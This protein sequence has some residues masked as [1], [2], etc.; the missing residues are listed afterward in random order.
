MVL[1]D[2]EKL[3]IVDDVD[4]LR[5]RIGDSMKYLRKISMI[6]N[7]G[8]Y[9]NKD[10]MSKLIQANK[11]EK[12]GLRIENNKIVITEDNFEDVLTLLNNDRLKSPI[13]EETF[14]VHVK[15]PLDKN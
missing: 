4:K 6:K 7:N 5:E 3:E 12:W 13:T 15:V 8:Y 1:D 9:K 2:F 11:K 10:F 14:D